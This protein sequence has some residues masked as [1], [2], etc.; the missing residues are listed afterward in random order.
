MH[1]K[2]NPSSIHEPLGR[3]SHTVS[4]APN[5]RWLVISGQVG[6]AAN[7][8]VAN[9]IERQCER[10]LR[11]ILACLKENEM[12]K[13][14]LVKLTVFLTD[15]RHA[16]AFR[17]ARNKMLGADLCAGSTLL[18]VVGLASPDILV[19]VEAMAAKV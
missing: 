14:D 13:D 16:D 2:R 17:N 8:K 1:D 12:G 3:Y 9:G 4:V 6:V 19:E 15:P 10:A 5:A 7:G 11:N 18:V